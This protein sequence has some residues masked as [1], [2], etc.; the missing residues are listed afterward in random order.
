MTVHAAAP[1]PLVARTVEIDDP[2]DL[3]AAMPEPGMSWVRRGEGMV[4]WGEA[5]RFDAAGADRLDGAQ[6]W[7][8][9]LS[10]HAVIRDDVRVRGTGLLAFGSFA[11]ADSSE[12]GGALVVPRFVLGR[13]DGQAWFTV[14]SRDVDAEITLAD[15]LEGAT[16]ATAPGAVELEGGDREAWDTAVEAAVDRIRAGELEKVVLARAVTAR[17]ELPIDVRAVLAELA[18]E[19]PMCWAFHVDGLV[20]ATPELLARVDHGLVTSRVLAGTIRMTGDDMGDLARAGALARSS[21]DREEHEYA[22]R[23]VTQALAAHCASV[24]VPDEPFVLHLPNVM[25][26]AT[27]VTGVLSHNVDALELVDELHPSAAV[28]GT[29]TLGAARVIDELE[30]L[31]RG[32]Y[33]GPVGWIDSLGDGE[34]CIGLRSAELDPIDPRA[35]RLFAGCGIV[36]A[37]E[38]E[39]EWAESEAKLEPMRRALGAEVA[40]PE[41]EDQPV[42]EA[43]PEVEDEPAEEPQPAPAASAETETEPETS[44]EPVLVAEPAEDKAPADEEPEP[45]S[46]LE[47]AAHEEPAAEPV[48]EAEPE[49]EVEDDADEDSGEEPAAAADEA[50][51]DE[52]GTDATDDEDDEPDEDDEVDEV[53]E[54]AP[55]PEPAPK[56]TP[57]YVVE[58]DPARPAIVSG[59]RF[60]EGGDPDFPTLHV[61]DEV[62]VV[63]TFA[64][65]GG[66]ARASAPTSWDTAEWEERY[67]SRD[68]VWTS[69]PN[70]QLVTESAQLTPGKALDVGCG[71]GA[72]AVHLARQGWTV[73]A[74]DIS[75]TAVSRGRERASRHGSEIASR[76]EWRV[77]DATSS[78]MTGGSFD[79]V[80]AH[81]AHPEAGI[82][83]LVRQLGRLVAKEGVLLVVGHD[84]SDPHVQEHPR[85][86]QTAFRAEEAALGLD[87]EVWEVEIAQVRARPATDGDGNPTIRHDAVLRARR[88]A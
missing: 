62:V 84:P 12:A 76:I 87:D 23:S 8:R 24:N 36:A 63:P 72:D 5:A 67:R 32:R 18:D 77:D 29:P 51:E 81:F 58:F 40:E 59:A 66:R 82:A 46:A 88:T 79:L 60:D 73:T 61:D 71:E 33:A 74:V 13:R 75:E 68:A 70:T 50:V 39:S 26:L 28:C 7:W 37:S 53:A 48:G 9:R 21:K 6:H 15:A 55:E 41:V 35:L 34:W 30:G 57:E 52:D 56:P 86:S 2:G 27:D 83:T 54:E 80:T 43:E 38:P 1:G 4:A 49:A 11:F 64:A 85:L 10:R 78:A 65:G 16:G 3:I 14:I 19:Y 31:D 69:E 45:E 22:V 17:A 47:D 20:G 44:S 25:H 42:A